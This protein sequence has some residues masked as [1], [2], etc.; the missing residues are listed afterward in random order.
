MLCDAAKNN[1]C[2]T[3]CFCS[4]SGDHSPKLWIHIILH[5]PYIFCAT[6]TRQ[7]LH[8]LL[9]QWPQQIAEKVHEQ[10]AVK[11]IKNVYPILKEYFANVC[12]VSVAQVHYPSSNHPS[13][14]KGQLHQVANCFN[15]GMF[16]LDTWNLRIEDHTTMPLVGRLEN[17]DIE[18]RPYHELHGVCE[19][20]IYCQ[21]NTCTNLCTKMQRS[22]HL[23]ASADAWA[24]IAK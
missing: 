10:K 19:L 14:T 22:L 23:S 3:R 6:L 7:V 4:L 11:T 2:I 21:S 12:T 16:D 13:E 18:T 8:Q 17:W 5:A 9:A 20:E 24:L 1:L 15:V